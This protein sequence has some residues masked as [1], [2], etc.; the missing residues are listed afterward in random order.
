LLGY[1][2]ILFALTWA[3]LI[4]L[5]SFSWNWLAAKEISSTSMAWISF[6]RVETHR[7]CWQDEVDEETA[8]QRGKRGYR[9]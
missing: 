9:G 8:R 6:D 4:G 5:A 2:A 7:N 1:T 3:A